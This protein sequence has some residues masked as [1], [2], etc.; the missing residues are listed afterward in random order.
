MARE[1][2]ERERGRTELCGR[3]SGLVKPAADGKKSATFSHEEACVV[4]VVLRAVAGHRSS[5]RRAKGTR[6]R[7]ARLH[8]Y[9]TALRAQD[10]SSKKKLG[11]VTVLGPFP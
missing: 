4:H 1:G 9:M 11:Q 7:P 10:E 6:L 2:N 5:F 3:N 8:T